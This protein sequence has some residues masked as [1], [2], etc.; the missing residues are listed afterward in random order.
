MPFRDAF[1]FLVFLPSPI[2]LMPS[3]PWKNPLSKSQGTNLN[4][5]IIQDEIWVEGQAWLGFCHHMNLQLL[6]GFLIEFVQMSLISQTLKKKNKSLSRN[7]PLQLLPFSSHPLRSLI[8][9]I[10]FTSIVSYPQSP[11]HSFCFYHYSEITLCKVTI[12]LI[13]QNF[14]WKGV[15]QFQLSESC[16]GC[17][18]ITLPFP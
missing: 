17:C 11:M 3:S 18:F 15:P 7:V 1:H 4:P 12:F 2:S 9:K 5:L 16:P 10:K 6:N 8:F 14:N 13:T